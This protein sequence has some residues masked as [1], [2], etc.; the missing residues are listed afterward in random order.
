MIVNLSKIFPHFFT[1][2]V[3]QSFSS[4]EKE[5][6]IRRFAVF[7]KLTQQFYV[8]N[9]SKELQELNKIGLFL[10]LDFVNDEN[11]IIRHT[12]KNWLQESLYLMRR[13][14]DPLFEVLI[15]SSSAWYIT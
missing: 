9:P 2:V 14:L 10:M 11:P 8:N 1:E 4:N 15:Q 6:A 12:A 7:W 3:A 5:A 13:I